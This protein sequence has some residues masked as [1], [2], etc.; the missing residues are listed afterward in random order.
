MTPS[1]NAPLIIEIMNNYVYGNQ[2]IVVSTF[3]KMLHVLEKLKPGLNNFRK[4]LWIDKNYH[5][6]DLFSKQNTK[7]CRWNISREGHRINEF[8]TRT[9]WFINFNNLIKLLSH[10]VNN[11]ILA[12]KKHKNL[13]AWSNAI[14][15]KSTAGIY[16]ISFFISIFLCCMTFEL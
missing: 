13:L 6:L 4:T 1:K 14:N 5:S 8:N 10:H 3:Y 7:S 11:A 15:N 16:Y 9:H 2:E 12:K